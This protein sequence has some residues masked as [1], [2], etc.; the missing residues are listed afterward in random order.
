MVGNKII[1]KDTSS[2]YISGIDILQGKIETE[3]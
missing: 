3:K 2:E 1:V